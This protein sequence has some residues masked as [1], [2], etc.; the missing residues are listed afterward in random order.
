MENYI[1]FYCKADWIFVTVQLENQVK[2]QRRIRL[3]CFTITKIIT[4]FFRFI[5][6]DL[7]VLTEFIS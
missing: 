7:T 6:S 5:F 1:F 3:T 4:Y 2:I